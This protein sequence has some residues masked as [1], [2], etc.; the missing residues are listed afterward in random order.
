[1]ENEAAA[2]TEVVIQLIQK[3]LK[4]VPKINEDIKKLV[5]EYNQKGGGRY[6]AKELTAI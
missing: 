5:A 6:K 4:E 1:M 2:L 3:R